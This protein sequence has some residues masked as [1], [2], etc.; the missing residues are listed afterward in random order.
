[1]VAVAA[2]LRRQLWKGKKNITPINSSSLSTTFQGKTL[3][4][5]SILLFLKTGQKFHSFDTIEACPNSIELKMS[6]FRKDSSG[7]KGE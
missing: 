6:N 2:P 1:M 5:Q 4:I 7:P 3:G